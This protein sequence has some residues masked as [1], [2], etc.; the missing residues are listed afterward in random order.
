MEERI[1]KL[2]IQTPAQQL[3]F[4][5]VRIEAS[6]KDK[7]GTSTGTAFVF[8]YPYQDGDALFL[9]TNKHVVADSDTSKF[10]FTVSDGEKPLIGQRFDIDLHGQGWFG[11]PEPNIDITI[12]PLV[13]IIIEI[14][15]T[16]K[17]VFFKTIPHSFIP[18][19]S[20]L[21]ELDALEQVTFVGY[22]NGIYDTK[23]L[24]PII[25]KGTT[26]SPLQ[27]DYQGEP[28][29]LIDAS[30]F[31]GSSGSPVFICDT[32]GYAS[33]GGFTIGSRVL[34]LGVIASVLIREADD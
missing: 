2:D 17:H 31:P 8:S 24:L 33:K 26:A 21:D 4:T 25:R 23:N 6:N 13:P 3:F 18:T 22:P 20:Q 28:T 10:F 19:S 32:G 7:Q 15:K 29:F 14:E 1:A 16:G 30:V 27:I 5:T 11:H 12:T 9:V 34:F